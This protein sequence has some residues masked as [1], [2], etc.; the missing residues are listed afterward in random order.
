V[1][2]E[3]RPT[4]RLARLGC[5]LY[6]MFGGFY[7]IGGMY[8]RF[9]GPC[10]AFSSNTNCYWSPEQRFWIFPGSQIAIFAVGILLAR[11]VRR[12]TR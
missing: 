6:L 1:S 9:M 2:D 5:A 10:P 11:Y 8:V 7:A 12:S 3:Q 4:A